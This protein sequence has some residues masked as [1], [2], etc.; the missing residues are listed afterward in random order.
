MAEVSARPRRR[1]GRRLLVTLIVLLII[2]GGIAVAADR[3]GVGFAERMVADRVAQ[4]VKD[5]QASSAAPEVTIEGFP[6]L[7]QVVAGN[8]QEIKILLRD[9]SGPAG[10]NRTLKMPLLDIRA[11]DVKAD[12]NTVRTGQGEITASRVTGTGTIAYADVTALANQEGVQLGEKDG[13]LAVKAQRKFGAQTVAVD[14]K[15]KLTIEGNTVQV[16]FEQVT[17]PGLPSIPLIDNLLTTYAKNL[18]F[19]FQLPA[20]PLGLKVTKLQPTPGGLVVEAAADQ[21]PLT[22]AK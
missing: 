19:A 1:W 5:R 4:Q 8:Y 7:T 9:F 10:E 13:L 20:L 15:A 12:L 3:L 11:E 14:G 17:A 18:S 2:L 16:R 6:F 22:N 21:V